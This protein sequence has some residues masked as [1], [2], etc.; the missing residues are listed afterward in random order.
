[1]ELR[2]VIIVVET[3]PINMIFP[4]QDL[5]MFDTK[6]ILKY[7]P[8]V[9]ATKQSKRLN[10]VSTIKTKN[11]RRPASFEVACSLGGVFDKR[12]KNLLADSSFAE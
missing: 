5:F 1:M 12:S 6:G 4:S 2:M 7:V 8:I 3:K 9:I 11:F 10:K